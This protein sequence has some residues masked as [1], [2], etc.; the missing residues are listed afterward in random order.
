MATE[1]EAVYPS[2][3]RGELERR[4]QAVWK[5]MQE[6]GLDALVLYGDSSG[7]FANFA[8]VTYLTNYRDRLFSYVIVI[9]EREPMLLISNPLY[10]PTAYAMAQV[11]SIDHVTWDPGGR[12]ADVLKGLGV[13]SGRIGLVGTAGIQKSS[14][15][16][17]HMRAMEQALSGATWEEATDILQTVRRIKSAEEIE[18][19]RRG[20][21]FTDATV[22]AV[23]AEA[24][25]GMTDHDIATIIARTG[26]ERG[27]DP[28][29]LFVGSTPIAD[30]QIR[31]PLQFPS[32]RQTRPG[33]IVLVELSTE[34]MG[35][36]G[37]IHR[38]FLV[39]TEPP[40]VFDELFRV[41]K[42]VYEAVLG[43]LGPGAT[44]DDLRNAAGPI[45]REAG[46]W[47]TDALLHGWGLGL[48]PPR[49]DVLDVTTIERPQESIVFEPGMTMVLQPHVLSPDKNRGLQLGSLVVIT[50]NG[51]E[52]LQKHRMEWL[53]ISA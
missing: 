24:R 9:P 5:A 49:L 12:I 43:V 19:L 10:L 53:P 26:L 50:D 32:H 35:Y 33:D 40:Q 13:G 51:V 2:L 6:R 1:A 29:T 36:S 8:N 27:G 20:A 52:A 41:T 14:L 7:V 18:Y 17:E 47:T 46:M 44:D 34:Y 11:E 4:H 15:P 16:Y 23:E 28:R 22:A 37:Q 31:F 30:P 48:E 3:S 38:A 42:E 21:E 39:E 25:V 45:I